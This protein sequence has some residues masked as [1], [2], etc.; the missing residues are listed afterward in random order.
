VGDA[1]GCLPGGRLSIVKYGCRQKRNPGGTSR[2]TSRNRKLGILLVLVR[3]SPQNQP[4]SRF[5]SPRLPSVRPRNG[6]PCR[7]QSRLRFCRPCAQPLF[8]PVPGRD[9]CPDISLSLVE[10]CGTAAGET[11]RRFQSRS[12]GTT[13][14]PI[15]HAAL[16]K[17]DISGTFPV[18][19]NLTALASRLEKTCR[20][21]M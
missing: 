5:P 12:P 3:P 20:R 16:G 11:L 9:L 18:S 4:F 7:V 19:T 17:I 13:V 21:P 10:K 6:C 15:H 1:N 2:I 8:S 14:A